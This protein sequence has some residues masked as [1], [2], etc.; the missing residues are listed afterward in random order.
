MIVICFFFFSFPFSSGGAHSLGVLCMM[1]M[2]Q[3]KAELINSSKHLVLKSA[4]PSPL[5]ASRGFFGCKHFSE[6]NDFLLKK[7][8]KPI[9]WC[10]LP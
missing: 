7:G 10:D 4:H 3:K 5:S 8:K 6:A 9:D 2:V 1:T